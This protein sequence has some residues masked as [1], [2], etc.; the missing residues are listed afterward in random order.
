M[1]HIHTSTVTTNLSTRNIN[2][3]IEATS[4][5]VNTSEASL[6]KA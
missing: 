3:L 6:T 5:S 1:K 4:P 2:R